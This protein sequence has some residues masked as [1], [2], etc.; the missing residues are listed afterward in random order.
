METQN[1]KEPGPFSVLV[2]DPDT[3]LSA[4][5]FRAEIEYSIRE[6]NKKL[7]WWKWKC[8]EK[9]LAYGT[10]ELAK[11]ECIVKAREYWNRGVYDSVSVVE[12]RSYS[13]GNGDCGTDIV[14]IW[15]NGRWC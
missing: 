4:R 6:I 2:R 1:I 10:L 14:T 12:E 15:K 9:T 3:G 13:D 8:I 11:R 7:L 5:S